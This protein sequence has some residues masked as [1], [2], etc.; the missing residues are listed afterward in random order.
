[1]GE[2]LDT[3]I[4][5][6]RQGW[7]EI[8]AGETRPI[9][10]LWDGVDEN[11]YIKGVSTTVLMEELGRRGYVVITVDDINDIKDTMESWKP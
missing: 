8:L 2:E 5:S 3:T 11:T 4:E 6:F 7:K 9:S 10:E 1:M